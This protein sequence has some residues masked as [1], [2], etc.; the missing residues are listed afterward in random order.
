[1]SRGLHSPR[2]VSNGVTLVYACLFE[3]PCRYF[4]FLYHPMAWPVFTQIHVLLALLLP[5]AAFAPGSP[6]VARTQAPR[7]TARPA[8]YLYHGT[9]S[10]DALCLTR[11]R[12]PSLVHVFFSRV[13]CFVLCNMHGSG[14]VS[15]AHAGALGFNPT[16]RISGIPRVG[17]VGPCI[18]ASNPGLEKV[19]GCTA[20]N[21][22]PVALDACRKDA[23]VV[24]HFLKRCTGGRVLRSFVTSAATIH[25]SCQWLLQH[26][27]GCRA[28]FLESLRQ[29][30]SLSF[31]V[32]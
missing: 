17:W 27:T 19:H 14:M 31:G 28:R 11:Y 16:L 10:D 2:G 15:F 3:C 20:N 7:W 18:H 13:L 24:K 9:I 30:T 32:P 4:C 22:R 8:T 26:C 5:P 12:M 6:F 23:P 29:T 25:P 21:W 1:M